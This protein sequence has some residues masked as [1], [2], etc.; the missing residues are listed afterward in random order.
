MVKKPISLLADLLLNS[1]I[2]IKEIKYSYPQKAGTSKML[3][4]GMSTIPFL[5]GLNIYLSRNRS[6]N[7]LKLMIRG[8]FLSSS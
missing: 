3:E 6:Q 7:S 1:S 4:I 8:Q 2:D 5:I